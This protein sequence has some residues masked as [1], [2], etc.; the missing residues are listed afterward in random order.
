MKKYAVFYL[1][2]VKVDLSSAMQWYAQQQEGLDEHFV[3]A[4]KEAVSNIIK[5]PSAYA[6]RYKNVRIAHTKIFPYN[7]HFY[8]DEAKKQIIIT[9]IVH[10]KR[11]DAVS[12]DR[13]IL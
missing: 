9:G 6:S 12:L 11:N 8:I 5:M 13:S 4:V 7:I 2:E 3:S 1:D 10:N